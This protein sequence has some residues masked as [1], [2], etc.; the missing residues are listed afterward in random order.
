[1]QKINTS[2]NDDID[3]ILMNSQSQPEMRVTFK[4]AQPMPT[5]PNEPTN[6]L[7]VIEKIYNRGPNNTTLNNRYADPPMRESQHIIIPK[8]SKLNR[9]RVNNTLLMAGGS[10]LSD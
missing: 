9:S 10:S 7:N 3:K 8:K 2:K 6:A 4:L 1:M 5:L